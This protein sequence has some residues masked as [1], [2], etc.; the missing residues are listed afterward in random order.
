MAK[1]QVSP[2]PA[3]SAAHRLSNF[4]LQASQSQLMGRT[5]VVPSIIAG[6]SRSEDA[7][8]MNSPASGLAVNQPGDSYEQE[9][10]RVAEQVMRMSAPQPVTVSGECSGQQGLRRKCAECEDEAELRRSASGVGPATAPASVHEVLRAS[11]QPLDL[12][13]CHRNK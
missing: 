2:R 9:A 6:S 8:L 4:R 12:V 3:L 10:D 1:E 11:G 13:S 7:G 5:A